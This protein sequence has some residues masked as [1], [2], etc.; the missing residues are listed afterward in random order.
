MF[1]Y[2]LTVLLSLLLAGSLV[3][4]VLALRA[5]AVYKRQRY[6]PS[7]ELPFISVMRPLA[8][9]EEGLRENL[10]SFFEQDY[11]EFELIFGVASPDDPAVAIAR[12]VMAEHPRTSS[13]LLIAGESPTPNR[14]VQSLRVMSE[15]ARYSIFLMADS[16]V[17]AGADLLRVVGSEMRSPGV[18]LVTCP[19]RA[20]G[21]PSAW[22]AMEAIGLNTEFLAQILVARML[23]GMDFALGPTLAI[24]REA[25]D[26]IGGFDE[27]RQ[28]LAEDFVMGNRTAA[29]GMKVLLSSFVVEHRLG[30]QGFVSNFSHRLRWARSTRRSRPWGYAGQL[31][32]N[33]LPLA[34]LLVAVRPVAWPALVATVAIR[35]AVAVATSQ[36]VLRDPLTRALWWLVPIQDVAS[37]IV[38]IGGFFGSHITWR[39]KRL[40]V[41]SDGR[42]ESGV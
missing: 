11:P 27:L 13:R 35:A 21:G 2:P 5:V 39:G 20:S 31:F 12:Q 33:S 41:L 9:A 24:R 28:Y 18:A 26:A 15:A 29:K 3:Y 8:G 7:R 42:F 4:C 16:D 40:K 32:T 6:Q 19:Y 22:S 14:K 10:A 23:G 34:L 25:L 38:W 17:R 37:F 30:S 1:V 36:W